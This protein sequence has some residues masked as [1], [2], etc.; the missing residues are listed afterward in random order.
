MLSF[1]FGY[2]FGGFLRDWHDGLN[3]KKRRRIGFKSLH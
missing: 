1:I 2:T 3:F